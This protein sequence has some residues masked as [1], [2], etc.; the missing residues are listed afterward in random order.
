M[1]EQYDDDTNEPADNYG[2]LYV[3]GTPVELSDPYDYERVQVEF[4]DTANG[5]QSEAQEAGPLGWCNSA[6]ITLDRDD[7][8]V[9]VSI[10]VGDPR[11]AFGFTV[12]RLPQGNSVDPNGQP[13]L[14]MHLPYPGEPMPHMTLSELHTGTY[15]IS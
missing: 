8:A 7:D 15:R 10:S 1:G 5:M 12:R 9:H 6:A 3:D 14:V 11:G 4:D 2:T 13:V